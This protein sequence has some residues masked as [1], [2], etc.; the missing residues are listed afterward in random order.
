MEAEHEMVMYSEV[1][2]VRHEDGR[3]SE[4]VSPS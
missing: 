2:L 3:G 4:L 1:V